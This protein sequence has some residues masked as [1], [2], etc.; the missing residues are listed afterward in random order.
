VAEANLT[1]EYASRPG[2]VRRRWRRA[3]L[4]ILLLGAIIAGGW[5]RHSI[6]WAVR[7]GLLLRA[8][9]Q[10]L[11]FNAQ[12]GR[13]VYEEDVAR[14]SELL[15]QPDYRPTKLGPDGQRIG[16][17][18]WPAE[19]RNYP[20]A[21]LWPN[22]GAGEEAL[23]FL[24]ERKTASGQSVLVS[25]K[26]WM[27]RRLRRVQFGSRAVS[28]ATWNS[29]SQTVGG[30][31]GGAFEISDYYERTPLRIYAGNLDPADASRFTV[32][33]EL[34]GLRGVLKGRVKDSSQPPGTSNLTVELE[35]E[36]QRG[37]PSR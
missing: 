34:N 29:D 15:K 5:C 4:V 31:H 36:Y 26:A 13:V 8:Q 24:H 33:Y 11:D 23:L 16:A 32:E 19:I 22:G 35:L 28:L 7:R 1:L 27:D 12:P 21:S 6:T 14:A 10:C 37:E 9:R 18:W 3:T 30:L 17:A 25:V 20:E 2:W